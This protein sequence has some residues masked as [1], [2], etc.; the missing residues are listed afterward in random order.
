MS[1][2]VKNYQ[3]LLA[4]YRL[5]YQLHQIKSL[6]KQQQMQKTFSIKTLLL[7]FSLFSKKKRK[8]KNKK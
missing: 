4:S 1:F 7:K 5:V 3:L 2:R 8:E 6:L